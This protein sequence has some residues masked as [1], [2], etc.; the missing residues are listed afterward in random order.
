MFSVDEMDCLR[1]P[2]GAA[3]TYAMI[4]EHKYENK[5]ICITMTHRH[6][7]KCLSLIF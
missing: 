5:I 1:F 4:M 3:P 2:V 7:D 6:L